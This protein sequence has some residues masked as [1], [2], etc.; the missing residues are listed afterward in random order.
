[1]DIIMASNEEKIVRR[2]EEAQ[3]SLVLQSSDL[4]LETIA[5]MVDSGAIDVD[6]D[7]QRRERWKNARQAQLIESFLLNVPVPPVYLAEDDFGTYSVIDGKQ[8][9]TTINRFLRDRFALDHL[10]SFPEVNGLR[11]K[12]LPKALRN[13]LAIRP[14]LR[15][16]TLLKQTDPE[17]KYDVFTRLNTGGEPLLPQ[18]IRNALYR[19]SLNDKLFSLGENAFLRKQLKIKTKKESAYTE[20][21]D[22]EMPL[23]FFTFRDSWEQFS[24][25]SRKS[26][27]DFM[28]KNKTLTNT[29][30]KKLAGDFESALARCE[31]LWGENAFKR[32]A[33]GVFR[34]QFMAAIYDAQMIAVDRLTPAKFSRLLLNKKTLLKA[35]KEMFD[36]A[37]FVESVRAS[38][39]TPSRVRYRV[40][41]MID[42]LAAI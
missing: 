21:L 30:L 26:M 25:N 13:A 8:R 9:I 42:V 22:V 3:N 40:E 19:G 10:V 37:E 36:D 41:K 5:A 1:M 23:R 34:D 32:L 15:V 17:L 38:T 16:V 35:T 18:E 20:M 14:Y 27:D 11:Y 4:S 6:P 29:S 2:F 24:G 33:N 39:N 7:Y 31:E 28:A 12:E